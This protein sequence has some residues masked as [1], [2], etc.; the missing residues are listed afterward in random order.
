MKKFSKAGAPARKSA[1]AGAPKRAYAPRTPRDGDAPKRAYAPRTPRDGDAP[2]RPYA[3]RTRDGDAPK[4]A[5]A[6]RTRDGDAPRRPYTPRDADAPRRPYT[7]RDGDA[8]RR[9]YTPRGGDD[10]APPRRSYARPPAGEG[11]AYGNP[12]ERAHRPRRFD[13]DAEG[14]GRRG[15]PRGFTVTLDPDVARVFRGDASVNKALRLVLQ[16]MQVVEGPG[17]RT[18][19]PAPSARAGYQGSDEA[20]GFSRKPRFVEDDSD[21]A[22]GA[23][24]A[25]QD[26]GDDDDDGNA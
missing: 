17:P 8:P 13:S 18:E 16:L 24:D 15:A 2:K 12:Y 20:R 22:A 25:G 1:G 9:P 21:D 5:Y 10:G 19:R 26:E 11:S 3:P 7:P 14:D 23:A 4:R 6:P